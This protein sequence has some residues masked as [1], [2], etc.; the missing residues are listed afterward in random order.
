MAGEPLLT[1]VPTV[2][3]VS[4]AC[5]CPV[6]CFCVPHHTEVQKEVKNREHAIVNENTVRQWRLK[7]VDRHMAGVNC[8]VCP[9]GMLWALI[10]RTWQQGLDIASFLFMLDMVKRRKRF[11]NHHWWMTRC[12]GA[13]SLWHY[14]KGLTFL[15]LLF[16]FLRIGYN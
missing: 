4:R 10:C 14:S 12:I 1:S 6:S 13:A 9:L 15:F 11:V 3:E 5:F 7:W 16:L 2:H 8:S